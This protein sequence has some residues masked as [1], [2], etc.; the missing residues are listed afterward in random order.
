MDNQHLTKWRGLGST[1]RQ[2]Q[3][4]ISD[5]SPGGKTRLFPLTGHNPGLSLAFLLDIINLEDIP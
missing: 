5:A 1:Q 3:E 2:A 4:L